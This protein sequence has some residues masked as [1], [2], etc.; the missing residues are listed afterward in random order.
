MP[1]PKP[2]SGESQDDFIGRCMS[3]L[4]DSDPDRPNDQRLAM[5]FNAW[6]EVHGGKLPDKS[7]RP[8][9]RRQLSPDDFEDMR[10]RRIT[11][12]AASML[13]RKRTLIST[14]TRPRK[15]VR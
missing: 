14:M 12:T 3:A 10:V 1:V 11:S 13:R 15:S 6:R 7:A 8:P 4:A 2:H 9:R 5:C